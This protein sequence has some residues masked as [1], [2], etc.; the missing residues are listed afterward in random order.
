MRVC[1]AKPLSEISKSQTWV[2]VFYKG[3]RNKESM[4]SEFARGHVNKFLLVGSNR[5]LVV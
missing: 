5:M 3:Q 4:I 2:F 1:V